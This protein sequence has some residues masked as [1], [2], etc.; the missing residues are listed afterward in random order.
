[1]DPR[2]RKLGEGLMNCVALAWF[3]YQ[4]LYGQG[5]MRIAS[6]VMLVICVI[7]TAGWV[8]NDVRRRPK[9][10]RAREREKEQDVG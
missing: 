3:G 10:R 1:M 6:A 8:V 4:T 5:L 7:G 2:L 9:R